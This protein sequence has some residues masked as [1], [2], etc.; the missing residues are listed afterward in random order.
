MQHAS[1]SGG[2]FG[3]GGGGII[4]AA[5]SGGGGN[6]AAALSTGERAQY[7]SMIR[8]YGGDEATNLLKI[9]G[10]EGASSYYGDYVNGKPTS[11]GPFQMRFPGMADNLL[12]AGIDVRDKS[13]VPAQI[14]WMKRYGHE[15]GSYSSDIWHGLRG[16]GG[17]L[18]SGHGAGEPTVHKHHIYLDGKEIAKSTA[19]HMTRGMTHPTTG[20]YHDG[21]RHWTP[22]DS[23]L[24]GV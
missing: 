13:T 4:N 21:S 1:Y 9:Y 2:G 18:S 20:P 5:W 7:A 14:E 15:H 16:H 23:G 24:V 11:F 12:A 10:T 3:G 19:R 17:S 8:Q 22:P 6:A